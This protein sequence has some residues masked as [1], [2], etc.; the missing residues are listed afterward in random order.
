MD[1]SS[2]T[3]YKGKKIFKHI[4]VFTYI[5]KHMSTSIFPNSK[6]KNNRVIDMITIKLTL[7]FKFKRF[8]LL[9]VL[10]Y[11]NLENENIRNKWT[12]TYGII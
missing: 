7:H 2:C 4:P 1:K 6:T 11:L 12:R 5:F 8:F 9:A 10:L 3:G